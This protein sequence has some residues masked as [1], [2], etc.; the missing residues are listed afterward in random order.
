VYFV[1]F[2]R[3]LSAMRCVLRISVP[4]QIYPRFFLGSN[5]THRKA[6]LFSGRLNHQLSL[7]INYKAFHSFILTTPFRIRWRSWSCGCLPVGEPNTF[8]QKRL[9]NQPPFKNSI[10]YHT[11]IK[12]STPKINLFDVVPNQP[13]LDVGKIRFFDRSIEPGYA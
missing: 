9:R 3:I 13:I 2:I 6:A 11:E 8:V 12:L 4:D 10:L 5:S 1:F 7:Q